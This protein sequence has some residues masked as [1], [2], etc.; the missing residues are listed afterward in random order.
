[1]TT[2]N[3]ALVV[4]KAITEAASPQAALEAWG[5]WAEL[6]EKT[7][8]QFKNAP[9]PPSD[10]DRI[11]D[12]ISDKLESYTKPE[13]VALD[14]AIKKFFSRLASVL[15]FADGPVVLI[16][17]GIL[18]PSPLETPIQELNST[19]QELGSLMASKVFPM[20]SSDWKTDYSESVKDSFQGAQISK[21]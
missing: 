4:K 6:Y 15:E 10:L 20:L 7:Y 16:V 13:N 9:V 5:A 3:C 8:R 11:E 19:N 1:M 21:P 14:L 18:S 17:V 2:N 12:K